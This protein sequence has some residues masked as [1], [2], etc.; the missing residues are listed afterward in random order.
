MKRRCASSGLYCSFGFVMVDFSGKSK[1][2]LTDNHLRAIGAVVVNWSTLEVLMELFILGLYEIT[3][4]RGLVITSNLSFQ[5]KLTILRVLATR[6]AIKDAD[7]AKSFAGLLD[8]IEKAHQKRNAIAHGWWSAG[9]ADGLAR[10]MAIRVRG[11]RLSTESEQV[12]LMDVEAVA[13]DLLD[14][15]EKMLG[16]A[17][18]WKIRPTPVPADPE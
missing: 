10:R 5:N 14:V 1:S 9:N 7:E 6:G 15:W 3:P 8:R 2:F 4:D 11:R 18:R 17:T 12:P 13:N 16:Y